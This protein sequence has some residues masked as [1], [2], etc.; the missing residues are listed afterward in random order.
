[1]IDI[2]QED[3][4]MNN[5]DEYQN[6]SGLYKI[7][8]NNS[9]KINNKEELMNKNIF[10]ENASFYLT[11]EEDIK[12]IKSLNAESIFESETDND[13]NPFLIS[14]MNKNR[15]L[16][17]ALVDNISQKIINSSNESKYTPLHFACLYNYYELA[18][19]LIKKGA[20]INVKTRNSNY[21]PLDLIIIKGNYETLELLLNNEEFENLINEKN[22]M[23]STPFHT[24]CLESIMCAK[25]LMK[26]DKKAKDINGNLPEHYALLGG[27]IDIYNLISTSSDI[28]EFKDYIN[29]IRQGC[30]ENLNEETII[31]LS[32]ADKFITSLCDNL[33]KGNV[34]NVKKIV[35]YYS[36]NKKLK[37]EIN[38]DEHSD[39]IICNICNGRN[40]IFLNI[41]NEIMNFDKYPIAAY[42]G[43]FGLISY[44]QELKNMN[45]NMFSEL[46]GKTLLDYAIENK[47]ENM[48]LEFFK[49]IEVISDDTLSKYISKILMKSKKLFNTIY[50]YI[51]SQEK[52]IN[53][54]INFDY[55]YNKYSLSH[56]FKIFLRLD[57]VDKNSLVIN[58]VKD[59]CR[60]SVIAELNKQNYNIMKVIN[61]DKEKARID[62][63]NILDK[64]SNSEYNFEL[65]EHDVER[66]KS[67][68]KQLN[69]Y[70]LFLQHKI[71]KSKKI[72]I[73][74]YLPINYDIFIKNDEGK[75]CFELL[76]EDF[77]DF[78]LLFDVFKIREISNEKIMYHFLNALEIYTSKSIKNSK[79][80]NIEIFLKKKFIKLIE[81]F[82]VNKDY[83][84]NFCNDK[85]NNI[86]HIISNFIFMDKEM[87]DKFLL[88]M[89]LIKRSLNTKEFIKLINQQNN[90]GNIFIFNLIDNNHHKLFK[91]IFI[92]Y[93]D[94]FDI[95]LRN[96][97]GNTFLH[98]LMSV[99]LYDKNLFNLILK[100]IEFNKYYII[101]ENNQG[102]TPFHLAAYNRCNDSLY[103]F[104]NYFPLEQIDTISNKGSIL[105]YAA[106]SNS[107][108]TL[109]LIIEIFNVDINIQINKKENND[110]YF[111]KKNNYLYLPDKSTPIYCAGY[112]SCVDSFDYLLSLGADPF[113]QDNNGNDAIDVALIHGDRKMVEYI[114]QKHSFINSNGKYLLS[115]VK[116]VHARYILYENLKLLGQQ[117]INITNNYQQNLLMLAVENDNHKIIPFLLNYNINIANKDKFGRNILHYCVNM[118]DLSSLWIVLTHLN[119]L[120]KRQIL[121]KIIFDLDD[122]GETAF[123]T[124][125]KLGRLEIV[126]FIVFFIKI[127]NFENKFTINHI[128]LLPIHIAIIN[129]HYIIALFLK[130]YFGINDNEIN[131]IS[132]EYKPKLDKFNFADLSK[133]NKKCNEIINFLTNKIIEY[134]DVS[135]IINQN[136]FSQLDNNYINLEDYNIFNNIL[137][138]CLS[139]NNYVKYQK[140]FNNNL[141]CILSLLYY[142]DDHKKNVEE[143]FEI[144]S[145]INSEE[146]IKSIT[147]IKI[148]KL[149]ITYIIPNEY[150]KLDKINKYLSSFLLNDKLMNLNISHPIFNWINSIIISSFEGSVL[151]PIENI[152]DILNEFIN[153]VTQEEEYLNNLNYVK[154]SMKSFQ[155]IHN[156]CKIMS[157]LSKDF[158]LLQIKYM[159]C[160]PP[161][162]EKDIDDLLNKYKI[163]HHDYNNKLPI[164]S[165]IKEV[166]SNKNINS[167]LL[168]ACL[169]SSDNIIKSTQINYLSKEEI[170]SFCKEIYQKYSNNDDL[171]NIIL[172][173][174][175]ISENLCSRFGYNVYKNQLVKLIK[176]IIKSGKIKK[177]IELKH[178]FKEFLLVQ[179]LEQ[180]IQICD[181]LNKYSLAEVFV[182]IKE[183]TN[184]R[185]GRNIN[186]LLI[187]FEKEKF[188]LS[189]EELN[190]L[191]LFEKEL[192]KC[193]D[194]IQTE[195]IEEGRILGNKFKEEPTIEN[196]A[197]LIKII[198][199][200]IYDVLKITPYLIQNLIVFSFYLHYI[201]KNQ[202]KSYRRRLGQILTGE[203]KS[204]IITE[205][206]LVSALMGEF[207]DIITSTAYLSNRDE[208]K[209]KELYAKFDI[210]SN[211]II[212]KK[213]QAKKIIME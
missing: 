14:I 104:S 39:K 94:Y 136:N 40:N 21:T 93:F 65:F 138:N 17:N 111:N 196:F 151:I 59:N 9:E 107:L 124:A 168:E 70:N 197:K 6:N 167:K 32:D 140:L 209:F 126:Y 27:R 159:H 24:A 88:F 203:G 112:Y 176:K 63:N 81:L 137:P 143:F 98:Y 141:I 16:S 116:N 210:S 178:L 87:E 132:D 12:P 181:L 23:N 52:F 49:N 142:N 8:T 13:L 43:K 194:Y 200:G 208:L 77:D 101:A 144:I 83:L 2:I 58:K 37:R 79:N 85:N 15:F 60:D 206:A 91:E 53:N 45:L 34:I 36:K 72:W 147:Q 164:Y 47:N 10:G 148:L 175:S 82:E 100:I 121:D 186:E 38:W 201:N 169:I 204:L 20:K 108:S 55:L 92:K 50:S 18:D 134:K 173:I 192:N 114:S 195:F 86:L 189:K 170:L 122:N 154:L 5:Y 158:K 207:A 174:S 4:N 205:M 46:N 64:N 62:F 71:V 96:Y 131:N 139:Q 78:K 28:K 157:L 202:R 76:P 183:I 75:F 187:S 184:K 73:L 172:S 106:I 109:R 113:I 29:S 26:Y 11:N 74:K 155:F 179:N 97:E 191:E 182:K 1:M 44:I 130:N 51:L 117:D 146:D 213:I 127:N 30:K 211:A 35:K 161:L 67:L 84:K 166:L 110:N 7:L 188:P 163:I 153:I 162:L 103:L 102:L 56:H 119:T 180:I 145:S 19:T 165:F 99:K 105:H 199:C 128:G 90:L 31:Q 66:L 115:L 80:T 42:I 198:N 171:P 54:T 25:L 41:I 57:K 133:E 125:C 135:K 150:Y 149:F 3:K 69:D 120:N 152:L 68:F 212:K 129:E 123:Y 160:I 22:F 61:K 177:L 190:Q 33:N 89:D 185:E 156:F 95:S 193:R 118:N 48:I